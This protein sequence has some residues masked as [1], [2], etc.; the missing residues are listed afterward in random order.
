M[1]NVQGLGTDFASW[2]EPEIKVLRLV[3]SAVSSYVRSQKLVLPC[4][5]FLDQRGEDYDDCPDSMRLVS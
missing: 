1:I 4:Q 3:T 5:A 2:T